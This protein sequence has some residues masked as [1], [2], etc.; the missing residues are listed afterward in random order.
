MSNSLTPAIGLQ[1]VRAPIRF[2][3][4]WF[5]SRLLNAKMFGGEEAVASVTHEINNSALMRYGDSKM[6]E[7]MGYPTDALQQWVRSSVKK[8]PSA[9]EKY[10]AFVASSVQPALKCTIA[11]IPENLTD[12]IGRFTAVIKGGEAEEEDHVRLK[13]A[14]SALKGELTSHPLIAGLALQCSRMMEKQ[15]RGIFTMSGRRTSDTTDRESALVADAG[16]QLACASANS[17][18]ARQFGLSGAACRISFDE[19][20]KASLPTPALGLL[21]P[22]VIKEN[23]QLLDQRYARQPGHPQRALISFGEFWWRF[24]LQNANLSAAIYLDIYFF[25]SWV[26]VHES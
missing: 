9:T 18:L 6:E 3:R 8:D 26:T 15:G 22:E 2:A 23:Y 7:L 19:L 21:W 24:P 20:N 16:I 17:S 13:L 10:K 5:A 1:V 11:N 25:P 4:K 14:C 12:I